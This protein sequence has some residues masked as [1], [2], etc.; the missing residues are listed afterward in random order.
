MTT[1][2]GFLIDVGMVA[3]SGAIPSMGS[4]IEFGISSITGGDDK[5]GA[6]SSVS[7]ISGEVRT[8]WSACNA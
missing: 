7:L 5:S 1:G 3:G 4:G 6:T 8:G 2:K